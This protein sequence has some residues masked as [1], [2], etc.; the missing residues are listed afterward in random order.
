MRA[1]AYVD[2]FNLYY[3]AL[4]KS[5]HKWLD[6]ERWVDR[7][8]PS[9]E[10]ERIAYFTA[11]ITPRPQDPSASSRQDSYLRA[12]ATLPRMEVVEGKFSVKPTAMFKLPDPWKSCCQPVQTCQC[13]CCT[14]PL[15]LVQKVEEKGSDVNVAAW[16][17]RDAFLDRFD[18]GVVISDDSDLQSACDIVREELGKRIVVVSPRNRAHP[19]LVGDEKRRTRPAALMASQLPN[20]VIDADGR[21]IHRP[22]AW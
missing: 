11:R 21:A 6:L 13:D 15:A 1:R 14:Q 8:M 4:R 12:L 19:P 5:P 9:A 16:M 7:L 2:G 20:P 10:V 3:G 17:M 22:R 18:T